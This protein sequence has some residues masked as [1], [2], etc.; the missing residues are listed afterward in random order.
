MSQKVAQWLRRVCFHGYLSMKKV[1]T[2][3]LEVYLILL[4][5]L[6]VLADCTNKLSPIIRCTL[7]YIMASKM[8]SVVQNYV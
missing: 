5:Y 8:D 6:C 3:I 4:F 7:F 2:T 1:I